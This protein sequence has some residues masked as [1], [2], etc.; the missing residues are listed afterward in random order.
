MTSP[1]P[2]R[3]RTRRAVQAELAARAMDLFAANGYE[4]TTIDQVA[5]A[6]GLSRRS[7]F[8]Y[9]SSK[10]ELV[11]GN[12]DTIGETL[13]SALAAR[14]HAE[15]PWTALRRA[16]DFIVA[17]VDDHPERS[18][19]LIRMLHETPEL[20]ASQLEKQSRWRD[21]LAPHLAVHLVTVPGVEHDPRP[22]AIAGAAVAS[23]QSCQVSWLAASGRV[24]LGQLLDVA[25]ESVGTVQSLTAAGRIAP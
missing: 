2:L 24:R 10:E 13:A 15:A 5:T 17:A 16:F 14:P 8:R 18:M 9:F 6:V 19:V 21:M 25:M 22:L 3:E 1:V 23:Y 12:Q 4:A 11:L 7:F 20:H